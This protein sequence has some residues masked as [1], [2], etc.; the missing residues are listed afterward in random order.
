MHAE[1]RIAALSNEVESLQ[2]C[3]H[4]DAVV[5]WWL[6]AWHLLHPHTQHAD[7]VATLRPRQLTLAWC[8]M[9][10]SAPC[11]SSCLVLCRSCRAP[12]LRV[13]LCKTSCRH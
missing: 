8:D 7:V 6:C 11:R 10:L 13:W 4:Q 9:A 1:E 3:F 2:V 12:R 5:G